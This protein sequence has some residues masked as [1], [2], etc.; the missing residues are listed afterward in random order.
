MR[1]LLFLAVLAAAASV[2]VAD[3]W[4]AG[5]GGNPARN[6]QSSEFGPASPTILWEGG[7]SAIVS[8]P[9]VIEGNIV[10]MSRI[11]N[12]NIP[13]GTTIVAHDLETGEI[14]WDT[15]LPAEFVDSW[16][17]R[18]SAIRHGHVYATRAG[19]TNKEYMYALDATT[20]DIVWRSDDLVDEGSTES[21]SFAEDGD[22]IVGNFT[23]LMRLD[24]E[25]GDTVWN[26]A[27]SCPTS[28]GCEA[29]VYGDTAYIWQA[30]GGGPIV[31]A[32][33]V[34]TGAFKYSS[35]GIG[36]GFVQQL[37]LFV[38]PDGTVY[39]PRVQNNEQT[40]QFVAF[41]DTGAGFEI[42][43]STPDIGFIPFATH[44]IGPDGSVYTYETDVP[45]GEMVIRRRDPE[46][47]AVID[48]SDVLPTSDVAPSPRMA[49][50]AKGTIFVTNGGFPN[51]ALISLNADLS[52][53]WMEPV[54]NVNIGG[55][56]LGSNGT[57]VVT[58]VGTDV[59]AYRDAGCAPDCNDDG[60]LN[61]LDFVCFQGLFQAGNEG[62][63]VNGDGVLNI[64][65]FVA[66][67][68]LFVKGCN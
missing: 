31:S 34:A 41:E 22:L 5:T 37:S 24:R 18:V 55:P 67:Q 60:A 30:S 44:A 36:G 6:G 13:T 56:A 61:I 45:A 12:F 59:R 54:Q 68:G 29:A 35:A 40:D 2:A 28:N 23:S 20:G 21:V 32:F 27:R 52:K 57:L 38:G 62:A 16:R 11:G 46:T 9:A 8:Q 25:T 49:I 53:R 7:L 64:L 50:D 1:M 39:A 63:D 33:D 48:S 14:L 19:N 47:G 15:K 51:G 42:K 58:G 10:A 4:N 43:W 26:V 65:D 17:S 66:F 3:D